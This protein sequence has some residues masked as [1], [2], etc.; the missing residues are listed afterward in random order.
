MSAVEPPPPLSVAMAAPQDALSAPRMPANAKAA[1]DFW[2]G[3]STKNRFHRWKKRSFRS[4]T[5]IVSG[6]GNCTGSAL[7]DWRTIEE[8]LLP[9]GHRTY[10]PTQP[11]VTYENATVIKANY[12]AFLILDAGSVCV[13]RPAERNRHPF[14]FSC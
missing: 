9:S 4:I 2:G 3:S 12:P 13:H 7:R 1:S 10:T 8:G 11:D 6:P 5:D 14:H